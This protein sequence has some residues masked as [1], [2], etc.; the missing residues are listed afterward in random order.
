MNPRR[1]D[2][3]PVRLK[4]PTYFPSLGMGVAICSLLCV[5]DPAWSQ[6][7]PPLS[8]G[9]V[10]VNQDVLDALGPPPSIPQASPL[11]P[12]R[13]AAQATAASP[14]NGK[15]QSQF[16]GPPGIGTAAATPNPTYT[17]PAQHSAAA[18]PSPAPTPTPKPA[19]TPAPAQTAAAV[20]TPAPAPVPAAATP[21]AT[22]VQT[23]T[24][25]S[26]TPTIAQGNRQPVGQVPPPAPPPT[27]KVPDAAP[28][29]TQTASLA[30]PSYPSAPPVSQTTI[31]FTADSSDLTDANKQ[32]VAGIVAKMAS[33]A[34]AR[35]KLSAYASGTPETISQTRRLSLSRALA[36]R[37]YLIEQGVKSTR[38]DVLALGNQ[39]EGG[40]S[41]DRVD[42]AVVAP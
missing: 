2:V 3:N 42:L 37:S 8:R 21:A 5:A 31:P 13:S 41:A 11:T 22:P 29:Q 36:V 14:R 20:P 39:A 19:A 7:T 34:D 26:P 23:E 35:L 10:T 18:T 27:A 25:P 12:P 24:P 15:P 6:V 16:F 9:N 1:F 30:T 32:A 17:P 33:S 4:L 40:G 38:I 28:A